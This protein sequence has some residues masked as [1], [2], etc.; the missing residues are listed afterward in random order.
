[1]D[2]TTTSSGKLKCA[3][4]KPK[5]QSENEV[6]VDII[7][8]LRARGWIVDRNQVGLF[9]TRDARPVRVGREG[10]C[11]W[12]AVRHRTAGGCD[13]LEVEAKATGQ[14]PDKAQLEYIAL[15]RHQG[16]PC[17]WADSVAMFE[18]WYGCLF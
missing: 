3:A 8:F 15:R 9:F 6:E 12:R 4:A 10:Q 5:K 7:A 17:T 16:I 1:M 13:Y 11:D 18:Q 14:K 2:K